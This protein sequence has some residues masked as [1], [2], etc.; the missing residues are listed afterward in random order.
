MR[1]KIILTMILIALAG[2]LRA[3]EKSPLLQVGGDT[4]TNVI[5]TTVSATDIYFIHAGGMANVKIKYLSPEWQKHFNFDPQQA[6]VVE[7]K[8]SA[9]KVKY[10]AQLLEQPAV[11]APDMTREPTSAVASDS[12]GAWLNDFPTALKQAQAENKPVLIDFTGSDWDPWSIKFDQEVLITDRFADYARKNLVLLKADF[13]RHTPQDEN[14]QRANA[15][16][17][18]TFHVDRFPSYILLNSAGNELGRQVGYLD[19][20]PDAFIKELEMFAHH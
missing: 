7:L 18:K 6:Q 17:Q 20:G 11:Q 8:Q 19:G 5:V 12:D 15:A 1:I 14:L 16:V 3:D 2:N 4:Y 10:H 9:D 13:P